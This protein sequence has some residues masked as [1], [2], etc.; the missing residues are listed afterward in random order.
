[1]YTVVLADVLKRWQLLKGKRALL[2]TGTDEH[3]MKVQRAAALV[4]MPPKQFC[5]VNSETFRDLAQRTNIANDFFIRTTDADHIEAVKYFWMLLEDRGLIYQSNHSG[6]YSIS[7]ETFYPE[8]MIHA[9]IDPMTG[10]KQMVSDETGNI[11]EWAEEKNYHFRMS[12]MRNKLLEFYD[13]NPEWVVPAPRMAEVRRWVEENLTDL[14]ISRPRSRLEWGIPV[15]N[16]PSQTI[17]VWVDALINY[18]T[19]AGFPNWRPGREKEGGWPADVQVVGKDIVRFHAVYWPALL[20]AVDLPPPKKILSH[21][22]WTMNRRKISKSA[23]NAVNPY[24]AV[25]RWGVDAMRFFLIHDGGIEQD[26]DYDNGYI[27]DRYKKALQGGIGNLL[28]RVTQSSVWDFKTALRLARSEDIERIADVTGQTSHRNLSIDGLSL[29]V[30][31]LMDNLQPNQAL[32]AI[33]AC[34]YE[35]CVMK[36]VLGMC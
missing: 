20:L 15:P 27:V 3:G 2:C 31:E 18:I 1:M 4:D 17:Y 21:A 28:G 23:G 6:W 32:R 9:R 33:A 10:K 7:D 34:I 13:K 36:H 14:S 24:F 26:A 35:V 8:S 16:D 12:A 30:S 22:H 29:R 19:K 5:D 11:V 25:D